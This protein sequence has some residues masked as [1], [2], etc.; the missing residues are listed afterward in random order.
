M[1][2]GTSFFVLI[3]IITAMSLP[4]V[5]IAA[6]RGP[7]TDDIFACFGAVIASILAVMDALQKR[8]DYFHAVSTFLGSSVIG[9]FLPGILFHAASYAK[10]ITPE[11]QVW[12]LWQTWAFCGFVMGMNGWYIIHRLND[13]LRDFVDRFKK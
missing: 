1:P 7:A 2:A 9:A 5:A 10:L 13:R 12:S 11:A 3:P 6:V 4:T 8:R